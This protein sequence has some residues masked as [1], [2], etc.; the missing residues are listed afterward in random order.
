MKTTLFILIF[1][2]LIMENTFSQSKEEIVKIDKI[3]G[4]L[5]IPD[6]KK[7]VPVVLIIAGSGPTDRNGNSGIG[8]TAQSYKLLAEDLAKNG[9]A[10]LRYDKRGIGKSAEA[11]MKEDSLRFEHYIDDAVAWVNFLGKDKRFNKIV[12]LGHSEG[13]LIGM[14]AAQK[15]KANSY[16]S[17]AGAGRPIDEIILQQVKD[18][19][20]PE[21]I[22]NDIS[23]LFAQLKEG[24]LIENPNPLYFSLFHPSVQRYMISWLKYNPQAEIKKLTIPTL[25]VQGTTDI[26][27]AESE[28]KLLKDAK[29]DA[30]YLLIEKMNHILKTSSTDRAENIATYSKADLPLAEGLVSGLV[31]FIKEN[32]KN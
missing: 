16:I 4:T 25:I 27:V 1:T 30:Q 2:F 6:A 15:S 5:L 22:V 24:K 7:T 17:V 31:Q 21:N 19:K 3:E 32:G 8:I 10:S 9:I 13:S 28:A 14:V 18:Q 11:G 26:Q 20:Q 23:G 29:P 12:I